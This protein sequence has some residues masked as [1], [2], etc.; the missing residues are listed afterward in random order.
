MTI[1]EIAKLAGVSVSAVS[2]CLNGGYVSEDKKARIQ[3][4]IDE[5]GYVP[6][7]HARTLRTK[8]TK[9]IGVIIP[10]FSL[11]SVL[12]AIEGISEICS[13]A[14][15]EVL[16]ANTRNSQE[17]ELRYLKVFTQNRVDGLI[18]VSTVMSNA[19]EQFLK[20]AKVPVVLLGHQ[21]VYT[22][23]VYHDDYEVSK[24]LTK[25]LVSGQHQ[26]AGFLG[27]PL[28]DESGIGQQRYQG[29][30]DALKEASISIEEKRVL[31]GDY[32]LHSGYE[33]AKILMEKAP[34]TNAIFCISDEVAVGV[35]K[36]LQQIGKKVPKDI[37]IVCFSVSK[38][39]EIVTPSLTV[40]TCDFK[41]S[42][43]E[44]ARILLKKLNGSE[45]EN[46]DVMIPY[47]IFHRE[48]VWK[49]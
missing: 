10:Q 1:N 39:A 49:G 18:L 16:L 20:K 33:N 38:V 40:A 41:E 12:G 36:Y 15:Y 27:V 29:F 3:A 25:I 32:T 7:A 22:S 4:I 13:E 45:K 26:K 21:D 2:R 34:D 42:G 48:S 19:H 35:I 30:C 9:V 37:S 28:L 17:N 23:S 8:Q 31:F 24:K 6:S 14:G 11:E 46:K 43:R 44:S 47:E 5:T